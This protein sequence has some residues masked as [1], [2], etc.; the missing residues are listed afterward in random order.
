[1]NTQHQLSDAGGLPA[2]SPDGTRI[3]FVNLGTQTLYT[4]KA[5][6]SDLVAIPVTGALTLHSVAGSLEWTAD[7]KIL[8]TECDPACNVLSVPAAGGTLS[9]LLPGRTNVRVLK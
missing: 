6:G 3:A 2:W 8:L 9:V 7:G 5:D 1:V 4:M